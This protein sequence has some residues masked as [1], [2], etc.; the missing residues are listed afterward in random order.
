MSKSKSTVQTSET[1]EPDIQVL[2]QGTCPTTSGKSTLT[3]QVGIDESD[4]VHLKVS[5]NGR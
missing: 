5:S 1:A 4:G 2:K 3:Y